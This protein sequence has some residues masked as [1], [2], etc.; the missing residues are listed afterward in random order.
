MFS[1]PYKGKYDVDYYA[2][3]NDCYLS[4]KRS[5]EV[6]ITQASPTLKGSLC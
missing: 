4:D 2:V 3:D 5:L 6:N 1:L